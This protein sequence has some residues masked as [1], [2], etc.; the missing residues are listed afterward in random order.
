MDEKIGLTAELEIEGVEYL[1]TELDTVE[2]G[3][4]SELGRTVDEGDAWMTEL[5]CINEEL[6]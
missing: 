5:D 1:V 4:L 6:V 2:D 3:L